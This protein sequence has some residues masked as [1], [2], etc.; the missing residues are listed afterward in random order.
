MLLGAGECLSITSRSSF[1]ADPTRVPNGTFESGL[2]DWII[3]GN[4]VQ[5]QLR[6]NEGYA[7]TRSLH[8]RASG[9]GDNG[10]NRAKIK[11][12]SGFSSGQ[13]VTIRAQ[14][15]WLAGHTNLLLRLRGNYLE[16]A[17]NLIP[18]LSPALPAPQQSPLNPTPAP[19]SMASHTHPS[20][21][22]PARPCAWSPGSVIRM[23][24][25]AS[26]SNSARSLHQCHQPQHGLSRRRPL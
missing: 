8:L 15:R 17:G 3:Q 22:Q 24:S 25:A 18:S 14:A 6:S 10:A 7:S 12:S 20:C 16:A 23:A 2:T 21:P 19:P 4:H 13:T 26:N 11:L 1:P 9:G 5:S